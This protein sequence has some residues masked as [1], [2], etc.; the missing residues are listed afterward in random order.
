MKILMKSAMLLAMGTFAM[1][2]LSSC[3]DDDP[4]QSNDTELQAVAEQYVANTVN[5]TYKLLA[6]STSQLYD[7]LYDLKEKAKKGTTITQ[8]EIDEACKIFLNARSNYEESEAFLFGAATD[9]GID[10]HI[11]TW[12]LDVNKLATTLSNK[13]IVANMDAE[14]GDMYAN[15][16]LGQESL[17]FHGI[18]FILFRNG[19]NREAKYFNDNQVEDDAAFA[20]KNVTAKE[21]LIFA[22]A[23]AGD[24]R[25]NCWQMEVAWNDDAPDA[26][27]EY[28][29][30]VCE[31]PTTLNNG[32]SYGANMLLAG[33]A[34]STYATWREVIGEILIAGCQNIADE[35]A[36]TKMGKPY[37]GSS[38]ED[39][40]YIESPYSH[41]S[42]FDFTDNMKSIEN[43]YYGGRPDRRDESKSI[44]AYLAKHNPEMDQKVVSALNDVFTK[45]AACRNLG[46][47]VENKKA[48]E[49][50]AAIE[51]I[52]SL[53][54]ALTEASDWIS[55][56]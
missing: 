28:I 21:E 49:V 22:T 19:K 24:L 26:H 43:S 40:N 34:G 18:E 44:H 41:K 5:Y 37:H 25:N 51:S 4:V 30:D 23:V 54:A 52:N 3:G 14:D 31:W 47:F 2:N 38:E 36:N 45:L 53:S 17:G 35:V 32:R 9:F 10:P 50:L 16:Q 29:E 42:F 11:D 8:A 12:P 48:P 39:L 56:N 46:S 1:V 6:D 13:D 20:G 27:R 55:K 15:G 33:N 7:K